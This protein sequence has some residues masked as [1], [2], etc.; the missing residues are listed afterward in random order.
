MHR[1]LRFF[2]LIFSTLGWLIAGRP[3]KLRFAFAVLLSIVWHAAAVLIVIALLCYT[4]WRES[5]AVR[6]AR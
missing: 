3:G 5:H 2:F 4:C 6:R 1:V